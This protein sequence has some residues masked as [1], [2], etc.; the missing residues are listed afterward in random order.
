MNLILDQWGV[1]CGGLVSQSTLI[2]NFYS[3]PNLPLSLYD[4]YQSSILFPR[5]IFRILHI[6]VLNIQ[7]V[8]ILNK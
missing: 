6:Y 4:T 1:S 7:I 5:T 8:H 2:N 3:V